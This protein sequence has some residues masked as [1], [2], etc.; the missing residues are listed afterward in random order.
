MVHSGPPTVLWPFL[1]VGVVG[2]WV[3]RAG[4]LIEEISK[5]KIKS[6]PKPGS[7]ERGRPERTSF[8]FGSLQS[9]ECC[10]NK[11]VCLWLR[12]RWLRLWWWC[13]KDPAVL[14]IVRRINLLQRAAKGGTQKG[15]GHFLLFRS[16]LGNHF[17]AFL[18]FSV[19]FLP[20]PFCLPTFAA[21]HLLS[22]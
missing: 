10:P 1:K 16:P 5:G 15:V 3:G 7:A 17:V 9:L 6:I 2:G 20:I 13:P 22:P 19:T 14:K 8:S 11:M 18:T 21:I 4:G 12:Q